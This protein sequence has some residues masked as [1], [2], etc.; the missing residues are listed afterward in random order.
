MKSGSIG[1]SVRGRLSPAFVRSVKGPG[2][3]SDG[4]GLGLMLRVMPSGS[5]QWLQRLLF[6]GRRIELG[7]GSPPVVTLYDAR[8]KAIENKRLVLQGQSPMKARATV[9]NVPTFAD[10][11]E[12]AIQVN[13]VDKASSYSIRFRGALE[14]HVFPHI[15]KKK[16]DQITPVDLNE[17]LT[18]LIIGSPAVAKKVKVYVS[19][20][21]KWCVGSGYIERSPM[22]LSKIALPKVVVEDKPRASLPYND[23][24]DFLV[25]L[26]NTGATQPTKLCMEFLILCASRSSEARGA[27]WSEFDLE[28]GIWTISRERMKDRKSDH[29]VPLSKRAI[30]ILAEA[31]QWNQD[32]V[33]P[34]PTGKILSD[35]TLSKLVR[36]S[37]KVDVDIHGFRTSFRTWGQEKTQFSEE[38]LELCLAH[39]TGNKVRRAYARSELLD[40]RAQI[41]Q[42]WSDYISVKPIR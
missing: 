29:I 25:A 31:R 30:E 2:K 3:Y 17:F 16:V 5:Q 15:G 35:A 36:K 21:M 7:L 10:A 12:K 33:F 26:R 20:V 22:E 40:E 32:L 19:T 27:E 42:A 41:M 23:I 39:K 9:S 28:K 8:E 4:S 1:R 13:A 11:A 18:P 37:M 6:E 34:S 38:A 14:L 24:H